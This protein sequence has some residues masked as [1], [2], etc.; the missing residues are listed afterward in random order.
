MPAYAG[1]I[2]E[3]LH[4][5]EHLCCKPHLMLLRRR[6]AKIEASFFRNMPAYAEARIN[7]AMPRVQSRVGFAS[8][9]L[10]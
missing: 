9:R 6:F 8:V 4:Q 7:A 2:N 5:L 10:S 1:A 3:S